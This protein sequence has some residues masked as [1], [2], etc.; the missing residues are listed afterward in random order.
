MNDC[1]LNHTSEAIML[2]E[3][4]V[5]IAVLAELNFVVKIGAVKNCSKENQE[6]I[7]PPSSTESRENVASHE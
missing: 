4:D 3:S 2:P 6:P 7:R 5:M 1:D